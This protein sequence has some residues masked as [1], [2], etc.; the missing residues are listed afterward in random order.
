MKA[1]EFLLWTQKT[2]N[3]QKKSKIF[4]PKLLVQVK[5]GQSNLKFLSI[6]LGNITLRVDEK[7]KT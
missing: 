6:F 2:K 4:G 5:L 3:S 7:A 1:I